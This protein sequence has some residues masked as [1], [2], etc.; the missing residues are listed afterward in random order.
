[1]DESDGIRLCAGME[2]L[3]EALLEE[4]MCLDPEGREE[5]SWP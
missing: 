1:M 2:S 5:K 4:D 3:A